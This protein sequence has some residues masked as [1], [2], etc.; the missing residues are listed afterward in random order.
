MHR[1]TLGSGPLEFR[2]ILPEDPKSYDKMQPPKENGAATQV[3]FHVTVMSLDSIDEGSMTYAADIFFAQSWKDYRLRLPDGNMSSC[4]STSGYRLLPVTW[5]DGIW[6]PDSFFKNAKKVTFQEMTIPN[7][8]IWLHAD[9]TI[10]YMVKWV[11]FGP[12]WPPSIIKAG[13]YLF[14]SVYSGS[15]LSCPAP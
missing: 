14:V 10:L 9:K 3:Y 8:Y 11:Q 1:E 7:H 5:L 12:A 4:N 13:S 15:H 6:R 2:D